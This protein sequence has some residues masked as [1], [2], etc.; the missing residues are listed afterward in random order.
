MASPASGPQLQVF[1]VHSG[2]PNI[3]SKALAFGQR[4]LA[5]PLVVSTTK[6]LVFELLAHLLVRR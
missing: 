6:T 1:T 2:F 3:L 4:S 5:F